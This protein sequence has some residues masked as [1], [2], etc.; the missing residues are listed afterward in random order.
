MYAQPAEPKV[1]YLAIDE[2]GK[3]LQ[4][5]VRPPQPGIPGEVQ[6]YDSEYARA[7]SCNLFVAYNWQSHQRHVQVTERRRGEDWAAFLYE[8]AMVY[9]PQ[10]DRIVVVCDNLNI[11][12]TASLYELYGA[13]LA[14][15]IAKRFEFHYT[16]KHASWLNMAEIELSVLETECLARRLGS[17]AQVE[18][19]VAAW[20]VG[21]NRKEAGI[22][23]QF[24]KEQAREKFKRTY[25]LP[26]KA[27]CTAEMA[28]AQ[29]S[30]E[31]LA[32]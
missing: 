3:E 9:Y 17:V 10:A 8:L 32:C 7:G 20:V 23:W 2:K 26:P 12:D 31:A 25:P 11:H 16:P 6:R 19:E 1:V 14:R 13:E 21:R 15:Q 27:N 5:E 28:Y 18:S 22:D 30:F 24:T 4:K 29:L